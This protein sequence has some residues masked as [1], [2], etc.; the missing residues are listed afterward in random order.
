M[1]YTVDKVMVYKK[2]RAAKIIGTGAC[3]T[4]TTSELQS[5]LTANSILTSTRPRIGLP[6]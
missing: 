3:H 6:A 1:N 2:R 5:A 4:R